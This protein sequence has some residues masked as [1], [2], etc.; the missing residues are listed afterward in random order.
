MRS[1][2][3]AQTVRYR[4]VCISDVHLGLRGCSAEHLLAFLRVTRCD[5]LFLV[6][7]IEDLGRAVRAALAL[8]PAAC[9][10]W[11]ARWS[12]RRSAQRFL[13]LLAPC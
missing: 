8:E 7:D 9:V 4:T 1:L 11:A 10:E 5:Y 2:R 12:W 6:G 13:E 3:P